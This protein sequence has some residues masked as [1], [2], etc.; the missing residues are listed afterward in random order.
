MIHR[1]AGHGSAVV[2]EPMRLRQ[3]A[4]CPQANATLAVCTAGTAGR[5]W[6]L[7]LHFCRTTGSLPVESGNGTAQREV[8]LWAVPRSK[9]RA[10][11]LLN[12]S[13][14]EGNGPQDT[15]HQRKL[16]RPGLSVSTHVSASASTSVG[17]GLPLCESSE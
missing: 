17:P 15:Q 8:E 12:V 13:I 10:V 14:S 16:Q 11:G 2:W 4:P 9:N 7:A 5:L 1:R 6:A 3:Q